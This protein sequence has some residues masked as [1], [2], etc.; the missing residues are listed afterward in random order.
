M[1]RSHAT[2]WVPDAPTPGQFAELFRQV[3]SGRV[4]K[5]RMDVFLGSLMTESEYQALD[6]LG[7]GKVFG[8]QDICRVWQ[9]EV[10]EVEPIMS[11]TE[12]VL[13][14]VA[15]ANT[16]GTADWRLFWANGPDLRTQ[17]TKFG[18]DRKKQPCFDPDWTWWMN[19]EQDGWAK[20]PVEPGYRLLN[21]AKQFSS[22]RWDAQ[23]DQIAALGSEFE[24]AEEQAVAEACFSIFKL[25]NGERLL[26]NWYHWGRLQTVRGRRVFVGSFDQRGFDV[27]NYC[28][29]YPVGVLGVVVARKS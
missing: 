9:M 3:E 4:T 20:T 28:D 1:G 7:S 2:V 14:E 10:P 21:F 25:N 27:G 23:G 8:Y 24:R 16:S 29:G 12:D 26:P 6:I 22:L 19:E 11:Y 18:W 13:R 5:Q 15:E 17:R